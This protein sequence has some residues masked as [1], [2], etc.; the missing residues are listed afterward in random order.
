MDPRGLI[1]FVCCGLLTS[2][3]SLAQTSVCSL[4]TLPQVQAVSAQVR[5]PLM[6]DL[7]AR[8]T[9]KE[10]P[11][12]PSALR[13]E[14][15]AAPL[16]AASAVSFRVGLLTA[17]RAMTAA[18]WTATDKL[19]EDK[20]P[21]APGKSVQMG[22]NLCWQHAWRTQ[23]GTPKRDV[24]LHEVACS[25]VGARQHVTLGF[26][27]EDATKLPAMQAV[28]GLLDNAAARLPK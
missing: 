24:T 20:D 10:V 14:Q 12:L 26:E 11:G 9:S 18:E 1:S 4:V 27:H 28:S 19:L 25:V 15:C 7:P 16:T 8:L 21:T 3:A 13:I 17:E 6:A 2:G 22:K 23:A 5:G